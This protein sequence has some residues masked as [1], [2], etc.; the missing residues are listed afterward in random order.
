MDQH[1]AGWRVI[2]E[3]PI[4]WHRLER[5]TDMFMNDLNAEA[6][7]KVPTSKPN[8]FRHIEV[9]DTRHHD[10]GAS[11]VGCRD[12]IT[13][14]QIVKFCVVIEQQ[15]PFVTLLKGIRNT[16]VVTFCDPQILFV[17]NEMYS[18]QFGSSY[19][20]LRIIRIVVIHYDKFGGHTSLLVE[21]PQEGTKDRGTIISYCNNSKIRC[22]LWHWV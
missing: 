3:G 1:A 4:A 20:A 12:Q 11:F 22:V 8:C 14:Q 7:G 9:E 13:K 17:F 18:I 15:H 6:L 10:F 2:N 5:L 21:I 19:D 16:L